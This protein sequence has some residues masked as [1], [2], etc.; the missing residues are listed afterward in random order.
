MGRAS[1]TTYNKVQP[2]TMAKK[3]LP[4]RTL[5]Q[6]KKEKYANPIGFSEIHKEIEDLKVAVLEGKSGDPDCPS[7]SINNIDFFSFWLF[8]SLFAVFNIAYWNYY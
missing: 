1:E 8:S 7:K 2:T 4:T 5:L 3:K 6:E